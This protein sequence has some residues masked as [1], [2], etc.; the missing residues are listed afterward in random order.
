MTGGAEVNGRKRALITGGSRGIGLAIARTLAEDGYQ[1]VLTARV[2]ERLAR[3]AGELRADGH[4]VEHVAADLTEDEGR[5]AV[6]GACG[7]DGLD[8]LVL[9]AGA[10]WAA[11][12]ADL[13]RRGFDRVLGVNFVSP[14]LL[15]QSL[16]GHLERAAGDHG[17]ATVIAISSI[18]SMYSGSQ[19]SIYAASKAALTSLC[20]TVNIESSASGVRAVAI[21]PAYVDTDMARWA[22]ERVPQETM[23]PAHDIAELARCVVRLSPAAVIAE[24]VVA[25]AGT[26]LT[27][28]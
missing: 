7:Q 2:E 23:M 12:F 13:P 20:R 6:V 24:I 19:L 5:A 9:N 27:S 15:L 22:H 3:A 11:P 10:G 1:L 8:V 28:A 26:T 14:F 16:M 25:R 18:T 17:T 21:C 4:V